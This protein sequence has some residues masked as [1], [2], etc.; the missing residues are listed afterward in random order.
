M[1]KAQ[2]GLAKNDTFRFYILDSTELVKTII[3]KQATNPY[4]SVVVGKITTISAIMGLMLKKNQ[5]LTTTVDSDGLLGKVITNINSEGEIKTFVQFP[6][7]SIDEKT[8]LHDVMGKI[9]NIRVVKDL[10]LKEPYVSETSIMVG[11]V[12][13]DFAY[14]FTTSEQV[15]TAIACSVTV[16]ENLNVI[17][18][19]GLIVQAMPGSNDNDINEVNEKMNNLKMISN[20][21][22]PIDE[23]FDEYRIIAEKDINFYCDCSYEKYLVALQ[24]LNA[25]DKE[26]LKKDYTVECSCH[27]CNKNYV[28]NTSEI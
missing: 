20:I 10:N 8:D 27:F 12:N 5:S 26:E 18:A 14:Y 15:A 2:I 7:F 24:M 4:A 17:S 21:E 28:I 3:E 11:D 1:N 13:T 23:I 9:G 22:S 19:K 6:N 25:T 16:D